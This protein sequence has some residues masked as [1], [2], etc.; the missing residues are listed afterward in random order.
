VTRAIRVVE[1]GTP[2]IRS[3]DTNTPEKYMLK[4]HWPVIPAIAIRIKK[5]LFV[6]EEFDIL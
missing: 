3:F 6:M 1:C 5:D 2:V 4:K